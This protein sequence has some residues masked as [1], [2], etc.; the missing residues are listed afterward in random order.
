AA[1]DQVEADGVRPEDEGVEGQA[2]PQPGA[3]QPQGHD[4]EECGCDQD[5]P[6]G[7]HEMTGR[8]GADPEGYGVG[9]D[10]HTR[11]PRSPLGRMRIVRAAVT[12]STIVVMYWPM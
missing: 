2:H 11:R 7:P 5:R 10:G 8:P 1:E 4:G 6:E 3:A 9:V 12:S